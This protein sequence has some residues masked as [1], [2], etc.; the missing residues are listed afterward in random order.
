MIEREGDSLLEVMR[1]EVAAICYRAERIRDE[2]TGLHAR[3]SV[4]ADGNLLDWSTFNVERSEERIRLANAACKR[5]SPVA[6]AAYPPAQAQH[7]LGSFAARI[8]PAW[9]GTYEPESLSGDDARTILPQLVDGYVVEG[10]GTILFSPP[11]RGKSHLCMALAVAVDAGVNG[12]FPVNQQ[13][14]V[15]YINLERGR[16]SMSRRLGNVNEALGLPRNRPLAFQNARGK[17]LSDI[18]GAV[19][20]HVKKAKTGFVLLDSISRSGFGDLT[21][22]RPVNAIA[23]ALNGCCDSWLAIA[24]TPRADDSHVYGSQMFEAAADVMVQ[25]TSQQGATTDLMGVALQVSK[26][27]DISPPPLRLWGLEFATDGTGLRRIWSAQEAEFPDLVADKRTSRSGDIREF[28]LSGGWATATEVADGV[29]MHRAN[30]SR[31]LNAMPDV[32]RDR[33]GKQVFYGIEERRV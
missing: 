10:G 15:L 23:D 3:I 31:L 20:V 12:V 8:W 13:T 29:D 7:D 24:H 17:S 18:M 4:W 16:Q 21:E 22:N 19:E 9:I 28:L 14:P 5:L 6:L 30:A 32:V 2:R 11:G 26:A 33:R 1:T 27:N 25:M